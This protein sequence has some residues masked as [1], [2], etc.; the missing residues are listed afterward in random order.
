MN[1]NFWPDTERVEH[2]GFTLIGDIPLSLTPFEIAL[3]RG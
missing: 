2:A 1:S 3:L